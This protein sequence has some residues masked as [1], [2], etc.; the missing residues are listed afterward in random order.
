M[1]SWDVMQQAIFAQQFIWHA[2]GLDVFDK[3]H[4]AAGNRTV[5]VKSESPTV[6]ETMTLRSITVF[7]STIS[8]G[9]RIEIVVQLL[10]QPGGCIG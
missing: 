7:V 8:V 1:R 2:F 6:T 5:A 3:M 10:G 9:R 4:E